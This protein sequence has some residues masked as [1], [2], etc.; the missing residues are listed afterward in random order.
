MKRNKILVLTV[1]IFFVQITQ[2]NSQ[3]AD[4]YLKELISEA[5]EVSPSI[6]ALADKKDASQ[7]RIA[8]NSNLPDPVLKLGLANLPTNSFSFTQEPMTGKIIGLSQ[9]IPFPGKLGA[10]EQ[11]RSKDVEINQQEIEDRSN[12]IR[13][14]VTQ[15]YYDLRFTREASRIAEENKNLLIKI[16]EVVRTKYAVSKASQQNVIKTE[17]EI[18]I[19]ND[20]IEELKGKE[21]GLLASLNALLL[22][23]SDSKI[24]TTNVPKIIGKNISLKLLNSLA[25]SERPFLKGIAISKDKADLMKEL[26][27]YEFYPNFNLSVSYNQRDKIS[28][29]NTDLIDFLTV[30]AGVTIPINYGGKKSSKVEE[31][32]FIKSMFTNQYDASL[33]ML[34]KEFGK[35][36][37]RLEELTKREN[38]IELGLLP[39]AKQSLEAAMAGYQ[40]NEIDFLN[41]IDAQNRLFDIETKLYNIR[42]QYYKETAKLE[43]LTGSIL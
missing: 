4:K 37:A 30:M 10:V 23:E 43:F 31:A 28:K 5:I 8:Q 25:A 13:N 1:L 19:I 33:Q 18:T 40:V 36:I 38:L 39:Q 32:K 12:E 29:S 11:V 22:R 14:E 26:A 27:E 3:E 21:M 16:A 41:V 17:V 7:T 34:E 6:K 2:I 35:S 24:I 20:K 9:G 15:I 42:T